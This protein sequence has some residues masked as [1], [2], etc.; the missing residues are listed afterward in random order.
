[1]CR[2]EGRISDFGGMV[3]WRY[4]SAEGR[5]FAD[6]V[7]LVVWMLVLGPCV[8]FWMTSDHSPAAL[9]I[10]LAL[11]R[12]GA[13]PWPGFC[14]T[15]F[16]TPP[17]RYDASGSNAKLVK[18]RPPFS[19]AWV[20]RE[21]EYSHGSTTNSPGICTA[22]RQYDAR[23]GS[24]YLTWLDESL[25]AWVSPASWDSSNTWSRWFG[26]GV[27]AFLLNNNLKIYRMQN[28][29]IMMD[30]NNFLLFM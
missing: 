1:M 22:P 17:S 21:I 18:M 19:R 30:G 11:N 24:K 9:A 27:N 16:H 12:I 29:I 2:T 4:K 5:G 3:E 26:F 8:S 6:H 23:L 28:C 10:A 7:L 20:A 14:W 15:T 13:E 25:Q